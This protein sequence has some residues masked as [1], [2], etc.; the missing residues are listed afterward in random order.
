MIKKNQTILNTFMVIIDA[1]VLF[2]SFYIAWYMR[3]YSKTFKFAGGFLSLRQYLLPLIVIIPIYLLI[4]GYLRLYDTQRNKDIYGEISKLIKAH[5][6]GVIFFTMFLFVIKEIDYSRVLLLIFIVVAMILSITERLIIR[7]VLRAFRKSGFN[8]KYIVIVGYTDLAEQFIDLLK[9]NKHWGYSILGVLDD[10]IENLEN[11]IS[12]LG[13]TEEL[14]DVLTNFNVDE[15]YITLS[16]KE[17]TK[18]KKIIYICEKMG[19]RTQIIPDYY[20][21]IP[22]KPYVEE[23]GGLPI[24]NIRYVPLDNILNKIIKRTFDIILSSIAIIIASPIMLLTALIIKLTSPGP[25]I[26]TQE[27]VGLNGNTFK[28][29]K[30]R[31][32]HVQKDEEEKTQWTTEKDPRKTKFGALIRKTSIDELPQFFNVLIGDMSIIGPRPERP[33]FVDKFK[34]EIP[35]YMVKH[36][37]RPG[38]TGWA[39]VNGWR[40]NTSIEKRIEYDIYYIENW[41]LVLD[42][43]I[44]L[45]TVFSG[46]VNKNAY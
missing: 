27:R 46:F 31:S 16:L 35:K 32:M 41:N 20:K 44:M 3:M 39:Q 34:E 33:Y 7:A 38:I 37:V 10:N 12:Y 9:E 5:V 42:L 1:L 14:E 13:K 24:I 30:F 29:Y 2:I 15:V 22:A 8:L 26:F 28:M 21:Y 43:K 6:L 45:L 40:G 17:Y 36:Q 25:I 23:I 18:L 4:Y 19:V 11:G